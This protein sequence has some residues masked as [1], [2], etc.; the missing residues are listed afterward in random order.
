MLRCGFP[1]EKVRLHYIGVDAARFVPP[2]P[3]TPRAPRVLFVGRLVA[4]NGCAD[5][6]RAMALVRRSHPE[7]ELHIAGDGPLRSGLEALAAEIHVNARFLGALPVASIRAAM[8]DC[9]LLCTP[10]VRSRSG[11]SEGLGMVFLEAMASGTPVVSTRH[12]GI[13]EVVEDGMTGLLVD[14][15]Q[16]EQLAQALGTLLADSGRR[17]TM[18]A[19]GRA[20]VLAHFDLTR[21]TRLL[22]D[23]YAELLS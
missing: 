10:S 23:L 20:R 17:T 13:P 16:P 14:E 15:R 8:A 2:S 5:L 1:K 9:L 18:G 11:D 21:Q 12:G 22:E 6:L 3:E 7:V 19:A 4:K